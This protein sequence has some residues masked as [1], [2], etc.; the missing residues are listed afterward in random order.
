MKKFTRFAAILLSALMIAAMFAACSKQGKD[1]SEQNNA[2]N[3]AESSAPT[4]AAGNAPTDT[5]SE[6]PEHTH[7][8]DHSHD[9]DPAKIA[10]GRVGSVEYTMADYLSIYQMYAPY[11][12]YMQ[13]LNAII[14]EHL[15]EDGVLLT[16]CERIGL[17]L[18][19]EEELSIRD[20][21]DE[22]INTMLEQMEIDDG[23]TGEEAI[24]QARMDALNKLLSDHGYTLDSYT[25]EMEEDLGSSMLIEKLRE[26]ITAEVEVSDEDILAFFNEHVEYDKQRYAEYHDDFAGAYTSYTAGQGEPPLYTPEGMFTVKHLLIQFENTA[27]VSE[28]VE[29][30]FGE[31]ESTKLASVR[32]ALEAG[33]TLDDFIKNYVSNEA[34][35]DDKV[36]VESADEDDEYAEQM[37]GMREYGYIM[38]ENIINRYYDGFGAAACV[39]YH[40]E[41]WTPL[42]A[43]VGPVEKYGIKLYETTD[44]QKIAEVQTNC[45]NGGIHFIFI[46]E[47]LESGEAKMDLGNE[48]DPVYR[49]MAESAA[50][51]ASE[52]LYTER[53]EQWKAETSIELDD[54]VI[55]HFAAE[56]LDIS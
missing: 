43:E 16:H 22:Y 40:G 54:E 56:H 13:D 2:L 18:S 41:D 7:S 34:Y 49:A 12:M 20:Q 17:K 55:D 8:H 3:A 50:Q 45:A 42:D 51:K 15:I 37:A 33:I 14:K 5:P 9:E 48:N 44:G 30:V 28:T 6:A 25:A 31:D 53:F 23:I 10:I 24:E 47:Q 38:N 4:D 19:E 11:A 35:N 27:D 1:A 32:A 52:E 21:I 36:F 39:L 26:Q 46:N 29:G